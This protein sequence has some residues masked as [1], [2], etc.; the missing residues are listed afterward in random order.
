MDARGFYGILCTVSFIF[1]ISNPAATARVITRNLYVIEH[2]E[3]S[4]QPFP[5]DTGTTSLKHVSLSGFEN[6]TIGDLFL[7][8]GV[9]QGQ[10]EVRPLVSVYAGA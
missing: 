10:E 4:R 9:V 8:Q 2:N 1:L 5:T 3:V 7:S 6:Q